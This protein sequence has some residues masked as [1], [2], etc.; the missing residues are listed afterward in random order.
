MGPA[1]LTPA[2]AGKMA[3]KCVRVCVCVVRCALCVVRCA[4]CD[5]R[6]WWEMAQLLLLA[7]VLAT[8]PGNYNN[9]T[10]NFNKLFLDQKL[11]TDMNQLLNPAFCFA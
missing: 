1:R 11:M 10:F 2:L 3:F 9:I 6:V 8:E 4:M 7:V 5:V